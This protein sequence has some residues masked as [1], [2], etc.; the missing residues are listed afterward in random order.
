MADPQFPNVPRFPGVPPVNRID[1]ANEPVLPTLTKDEIAVTG[2]TV[3]WGIFG[4]KGN[5]ALEPDSITA[6]EYQREYRIADYPIEEGGFESYNKVATPFD[7][8]VTMTK[9]GK[10]AERKDFLDQ[11]ELVVASLDLFTVVTP[12][13]SY[14][15][16]NFM[17]QDY[18]RNANSGA[19]LLTIEL[20]A[21]EIRTS[22]SVQFS[23]GT[24]GEQIV[25]FGT[26]RDG[27]TVPI[28]GAVHAASGANPVNN[29]SVQPRAVTPAPGREVIG[30]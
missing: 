11:V 4:Q 7:I 8:R 10:L 16:I 6:V 13:R 23:A 29:G 3:V 26:N 12:E 9:G 28:F 20:H 5:L 2:G 22:A 25:G 14:K 21:L 1:T 30:M 17:R 18:H 19:T 27:T 15:N 24:P